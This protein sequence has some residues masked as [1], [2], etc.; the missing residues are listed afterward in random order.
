MAARPLPRLADAARSELQALRAER[1]ERDRQLAAAESARKASEAPP[2]PSPEDELRMAARG[3]LQRFVPYVTPAY[4]PPKHLLPITEHWERAVRGESLRVCFSAPPQHAKSD[5]LA[6]GVGWGLWQDPSLRFSYATYGDALVRDK[7]KLA[8]RVTQQLGIELN[9]T[10]INQWDTAADGGFIAT[11]VRGALTGKRVNIAVIDDPYKNRIEAE[12]P[13]VR[14]TVRD[15]L[16]DVVETRL[17]PNGSCFVFMTRWHPQDLIGDLIKEGWLFIRLAA[18]NDET[19]EP[20][21]PEKWTKE[22]LEKKRKRVGEYTWESLYQGRPRARGAVVFGPATTISGPPPIRVRG[23]FGADLAYSAK[24][25]SNASSC[26]E[27]RRDLVTD[28]VDVLEVVNV[29]VP[30]PAFK[31]ICRVRHRRNRAARWRWYTSTTEKGTADLFRDP[32][33]RVPLRAV[34]AKGDKLTR[35]QKA[36]AAWNAGKVRVPMEAPWLER[37]L[38]VMAVFTGVGDE[39]DDDVDAF[40]AAFDE[41]MSGSEDEVDEKPT[42]PAAARGALFN[43]KL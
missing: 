21:W 3:N 31:K 14:R 23:A 6:H 39:D 42:R 26:V 33:K 7:S 37:F 41:V 38:A 19:G 36:A 25:A 40:V 22:A 43:E 2:A 8:R 10:S 4:G 11:S 9:G 28:V 20:L 16:N 35:A 32:P 15:F 27:V 5:T 30:A 12:S 18:L 1:L 13:T 29:R 34:L 24:S 17:T